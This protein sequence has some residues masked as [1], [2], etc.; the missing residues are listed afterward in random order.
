MFLLV[1]M[2]DYLNETMSGL[3]IIALKRDY[4]AW[5]P[6]WENINMIV[7]NVQI[8]VVVN[9]DDYVSE[10]MSVFQEEEY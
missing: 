5:E 1:I 9:V 8:D 6:W 3:S 10:T 2:E 4:I 7:N